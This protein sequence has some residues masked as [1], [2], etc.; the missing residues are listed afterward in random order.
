MPHKAMKI[1]T[2]VNAKAGDTAFLGD[3]DAV[4]DATTLLALAQALGLKKQNQEWLA[5][6]DT[7]DAFESAKENILGAYKAGSARRDAVQMV[8]RLHDDDPRADVYGAEGE[9]DEGEEL[10]SV[11]VA[12]RR[13]DDLFSY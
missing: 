8:W 7:S 2:D 12:S 11:V 13:W 6:L 10:I 4:G 9:G 3:N 1:V 5:Q